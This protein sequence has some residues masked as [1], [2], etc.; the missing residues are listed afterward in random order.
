MFY[1]ILR[2]QYRQPALWRWWGTP[3]AGHAR[4]LVWGITL[5]QG[6]NSAGWAK[7]ASLNHRVF[8]PGRGDGS[9]GPGSDGGYLST[10]NVTLGR[11]VSEAQVWRAGN[12][13]TGRSGAR[14]ERR[15]AYASRRAGKYAVRRGKAAIGAGA[16]VLVDARKY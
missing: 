15:A 14:P 3:A 16:R 1:R 11:D 7:I 10:A 8:T 6:E 5:T 12:G 13:A 9:T 2:Y 4:Q